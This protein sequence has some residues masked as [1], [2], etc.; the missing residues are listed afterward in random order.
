MHAVAAGRIGCSELLPGNSSLTRAETVLRDQLACWAFVS[1]TLHN[2]ANIATVY[3]FTLSCMGVR[4]MSVQGVRAA[5][6]LF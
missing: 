3:I 1:A 5:R 4:S 2:G 6:L